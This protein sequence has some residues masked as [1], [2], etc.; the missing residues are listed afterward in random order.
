MAE[1]DNIQSA[2]IRAEQ[3]PEKTTRE[4]F[5]ETFNELRAEA[6]RVRGTGN[7]VL[8]PTEP[9]TLRAAEYYNLY[10]GKVAELLAASGITAATVEGAL[11]DYA[12]ILSGVFDVNLPLE[13]QDTIINT[14]KQWRA[15]VTERYALNLLLS[16]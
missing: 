1:Q 3:E 7:Y 11:Q 5:L 14:V 6:E 2:R 16:I 8:S 4:R 12:A 15:L 10:C 9:L 13:E